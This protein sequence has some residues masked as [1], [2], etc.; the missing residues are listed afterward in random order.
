MELVD[1]LKEFFNKEV[2]DRK[3]P[4]RLIYLYGSYSKGRPNLHSDIDLAV[5]F[6]NSFYKKN[7]LEA[8]ALMEFIALRLEKS[9]AKK[10]DIRALNRASLFFSYIVVTTG[11]PVFYLSKDELYKYYC[12]ILGMYFDFKPFMERTI[13]F[14][15][16][17]RNV[18]V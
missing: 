16:R 2:K 14:N 8:I 1:K 17:N 18:R 11:I 4:I 12:K 15:Y 7:S 6:D 10:I 13:L 9:F 3:V 5:L